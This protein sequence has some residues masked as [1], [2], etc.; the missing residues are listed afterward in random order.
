MEYKDA[1]KIYAEDEIE[2]LKG[3]YLSI[4]VSDVVD[5]MVKELSSIY[6]LDKR[7]R[8][9]IKAIMKECNYEMDSYNRKLR[10]K[11]GDTLN[12]LIVAEDHFL[13]IIKPN[14]M[15]LI[16]SIDKLTKDRKVSIVYSIVLL[17][18]LSN[19]IKKYYIDRVRE[20][21]GINFDYKDNI[22]ITRVV[23]K[24][25]KITEF[26]E[27]VKNLVE[28]KDLRS[29]IMSYNFDFN[30]KE[31]INTASCRLNLI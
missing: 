31:V 15:R 2:Q 27:S 30:T 5:F 8:G 17:G 11:L 18:D 25:R 10:S 3:S 1:L 4:L 16:L 12:S 29:K 9:F 28:Y 21:S 7:L 19:E 20:K 22:N 23:K 13:D 24:M 14:L 6:R 26:N